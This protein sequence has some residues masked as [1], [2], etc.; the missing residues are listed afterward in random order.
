MKIK[1]NIRDYL[2]P[3]SVFPRFWSQF[4]SF[5]DFYQ[6][7]SFLL[8][9]QYH[10]SQIL[11][12]IKLLEHMHV[13]RKMSYFHHELHLKCFTKI[14]RLTQN[15]SGFE[16]PA[17]EV[18]WIKY[19]LSFARSPNLFTFI[20]SRLWWFI[21]KWKIWIWSKYSLAPKNIQLKSK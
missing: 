4:S 8:L 9:V 6:D 19:S 3:V 1:P 16:V 15:K 12:C 20:L 7:F 10:R 14:T 21:P 18:A 2:Q 17:F 13:W 11:N 5:I